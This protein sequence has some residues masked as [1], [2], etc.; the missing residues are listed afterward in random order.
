[1]EYDLDSDQVYQR[2]WQSYQVSA[3]TIQ[4]YLVSSNM[5]LAYLHIELM[6]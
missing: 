3:V 2:Q 4:D 1:M 5:Q 6:Y